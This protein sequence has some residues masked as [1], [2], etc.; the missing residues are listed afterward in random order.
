MST[1][2]DSQI[3]IQTFGILLQCWFKSACDELAGCYEPQ[4]LIR[5]A[6]LTQLENLADVAQSVKLHLLNLSMRNMASM[7]GGIGKSI[8]MLVY[9]LMVFTSINV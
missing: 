5:T 3:K 7:S 4:T 1:L 2:I 9:F 6:A 8:D